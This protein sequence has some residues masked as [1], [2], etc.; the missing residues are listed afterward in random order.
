MGAEPMIEAL[1]AAAKEAR[2]NA[3]RKIIHI[4]VQADMDP[5][6]I[7]RF[8][9]GHWPRNADEIIAAY[10]ADL[11]IDPRAIWARALELWI[12][13]EQSAVDHAAEAIRIA[14]DA[15]QAQPRSRRQSER[16]QAS[17]TKRK[18]AE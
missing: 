10:G 12:A 3:E 16:A 7:W 1:A 8:E 17:S 4:A 18:A 6:T 11:G 9:K 14:H 13:T 2:E 5:S 15:A